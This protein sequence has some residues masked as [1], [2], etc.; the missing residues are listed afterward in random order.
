MTMLDLSSNDL[1]DSRADLRRA[2]AAGAAVAEE[3]PV[4][5]LRM[6]LFRGQSFVLPIV[7]FDEVG[8]DFSLGAEARELAGLSGAM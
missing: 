8:I 4:W 5:C 3:H 7:P 2:F 1:I 6:D